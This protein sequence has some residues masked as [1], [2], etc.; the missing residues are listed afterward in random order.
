MGSIPRVFR[1]RSLGVLG[2]VSLLGAPCAADFDGKLPISPGRMVDRFNGPYP[3]HSRGLWDHAGANCVVYWDDLL[4][5]PRYVSM[6]SRVKLLEGDFRA[7][8]LATAAG[9]S[10]R[11]AWVGRL[12][13]GSSPGRRRSAGRTCGSG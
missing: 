11:A 1:C 9:K 10:R 12:C 13:S 8:D 2:L 4:G 7:E 3:P 5:T 6:R